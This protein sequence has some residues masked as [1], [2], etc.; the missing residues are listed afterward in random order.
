M[1]DIYVASDSKK[2]AASDRGTR[3]ASRV[4][5]RAAAEDGGR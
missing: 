5:V 4:D 2:S 3:E 1:I